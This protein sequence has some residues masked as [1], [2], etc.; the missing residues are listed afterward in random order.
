MRVIGYGGRRRRRWAVLG[1]PSDEVLAAILSALRDKSD[2]V[3]RAAAEALE[4][5]GPGHG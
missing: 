2:W 1:R 3:R 5:I 4:Q